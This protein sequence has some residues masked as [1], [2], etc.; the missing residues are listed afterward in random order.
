[1]GKEFVIM[2]CS[3]E[4]SNNWLGFWEKVRS[5]KG[6]NMSTWPHWGKMRNN[7]LIIRRSFDSFHAETVV[8]PVLWCRNLDESEPPGASTERCSTLAFKSM[9]INTSLNIYSFILY[10]NRPK[11]GPGCLHTK[12]DISFCGV[13]VILWLTFLPVL[14]KLIY[15]EGTVNMILN[16]TVF[17]L[18]FL[19]PLKKWKPKTHFMAFVFLFAQVVQKFIV[20]FIFIYWTH[21]V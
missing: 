4:Q 16:L 21:S 10:L 18:F 15:S 8:I 5:P 7:L 12:Y 11:G 1:M 19:F 9:N 13:F 2:N 20:V 14:G 6:K 3:A 17:C